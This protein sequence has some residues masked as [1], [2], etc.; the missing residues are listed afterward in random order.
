MAKY[1]GIAM[2]LSIE[3][4]GYQPIGGVVAHTMTIN[5]EPIDASDKDSSRWRDMEYAGQ[6]SVTISMNGWVSD[7]AE[8]A[9]LEAAVQNDTTIDCQMAYG[10]SKTATANWHIDSMEITGE[11]NNLQQFSLTLSN[12]GPVTFA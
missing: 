4:T 3:N 12:D 10:N 9:L 11:Y 8:F 6:R 5:N 1:N 7:D 2:V